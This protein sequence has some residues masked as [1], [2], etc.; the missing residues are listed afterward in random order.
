MPN[1]RNPQFDWDMGNIDHI[2]ERHGVYPEE[3]E[4]AFWNGAKVVR[5]GPVYR[6]FGET[7]AGRRLSMICE[8][9]NGRVRVISARDMT[10]N[11]RS[12]YDRKK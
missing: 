3:A 1:W 6:V 2:I 8:L 11:E 5:D 12:R 9:R 4:Q 10:S 7:N